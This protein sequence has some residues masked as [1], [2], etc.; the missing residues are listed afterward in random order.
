MKVLKCFLGRVLWMQKRRSCL[1]K[2]QVY[3]K[4]SPV[5]PGVGLSIMIALHAL[6]LPGVQLLPSLF[7]QP[8]F[9]PA[10]SPLSIIKKEDA[11]LC[12]NCDHPSF[13]DVT[14]HYMSRN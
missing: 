1:L 7:I 10:S 4:N 9:F 6:P 2:I 14:G 8:P 11:S 13:H 5:K 12:D 3:E